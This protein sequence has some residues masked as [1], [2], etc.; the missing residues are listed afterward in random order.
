[1]RST[2]LKMGSQATVTVGRSKGE[3]PIGAPMLDGCQPMIVSKAPTAEITP[4]DFVRALDGISDWILGVRSAVL[5]LDPKAT[6][7]V[8]RPGQSAAAAP[9]LDGCAPAPMLD[10]CAPPTP[11]HK[12]STRR[13]K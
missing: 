9:M 7:T 10:G 1:M 13:K 8:G 2:I 4:R 3:L 12:A 5:K 11:V 6:V